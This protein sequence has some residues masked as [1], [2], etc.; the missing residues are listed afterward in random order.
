MTRIMVVDD[1]EQN[2]YL[3]KV[4]LESNGY[5]LITAQNGNEALEKIKSQIPVTKSQ[6]VK[7]DL[8]FGI[9]VLGF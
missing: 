5:D 4:L 6:V 8:G 7:G 2:I 3:L 1:N 9:W